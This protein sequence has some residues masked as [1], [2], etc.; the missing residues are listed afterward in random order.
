M[1]KSAKKKGI[2]ADI[3]ARSES[4]IDK[5]LPEIDC[6]LLGPHLDY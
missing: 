5:Y 2:E 6:L 4:E 1:R 3:K